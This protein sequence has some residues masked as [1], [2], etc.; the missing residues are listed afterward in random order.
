MSRVK[1]MS[2][3][4]CLSTNLC[5]VGPTCKR[6]LD[7]AEEHVPYLPQSTGAVAVVHRSVVA[8]VGKASRDQDL[9]GVAAGS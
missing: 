2:S 8:K 1:K 5:A 4:L 7:D 6:L 9:L 3:R